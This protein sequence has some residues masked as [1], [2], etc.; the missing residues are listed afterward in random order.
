MVLVAD[1]RA[2]HAG[3]VAEK[4]YRAIVAEKPLPKQDKSRTVDGN[5]SLYGLEVENRGESRTP[6]GP[7]PGTAAAAG[8]LH[9]GPVPRG[10]P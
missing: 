6:L 3:P 10:R 4:V 7:W 9:H 2:N 8:S 5:D 1:G